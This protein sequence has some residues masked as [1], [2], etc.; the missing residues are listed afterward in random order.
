MGTLTLLKRRVLMLKGPV[1]EA[2]AASVWGSVS[3]PG[4]GL[5]YLF[6]VTT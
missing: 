4:L 1:P 3:L 6:Y 5:G 2:K